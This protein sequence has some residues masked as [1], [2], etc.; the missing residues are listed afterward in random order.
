[1]NEDPLDFAAQA[2]DFSNLAARL[3]AQAAAPDS[4]DPRAVRRLLRRQAQDAQATSELFVRLAG[5]RTIEELH[6]LRRRVKTHAARIAER[7][8]LILSIATPGGV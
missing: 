2:A 4:G 8:E 1:M 7:S 5:A 6:R 3:L